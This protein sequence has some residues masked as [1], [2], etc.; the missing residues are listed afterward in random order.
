MSQ[1][2]LITLDLI[3]E[4][5]HPDGKLAPKGYASFAQQ[6]GTLGSVAEVL[7]LSREKGLPVLHVRLAFSPSYAEQPKGSP[8]FGKAHEARA[9]ALESW[10]AQFHEA[11]GVQVDETQILKHRVSPFFGT[12]LELQLRCRSVTRLFL[13]GVATDL[14]VEHAA[15]DAHDRDFDVV[16][17]EECCAAASDEEH[18]RSLAT[19]SKIASVC[20]NTKALGT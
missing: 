4:I 15:R 16:V 3:N 2:A 20:S 6:N 9:L 12:D 17:L 1:E 13:C 8:L 18:R 5:I 10:G 14:A 11:L 19:M 7:R